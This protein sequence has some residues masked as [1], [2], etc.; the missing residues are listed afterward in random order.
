MRRHLIL[1]PLV[2]AACAPTPDSHKA[3]A[4]VASAAATPAVKPTAD[5][6]ADAAVLGAY[7]WRLQQ[8]ADGAGQRIDALF[9]RAD[10]PLQLD[11]ADGR[12]SVRNSC[13][14]M[15]GSYRVEN[16]QLVVGP[17]M[18]TMMACADL[19]LNQLDGAIS[20]RL[21]ARPAIAIGRQG[22]APQ[23]TLRTASGDQL[24]FA[25]VP[26]PETRYGGPGTTEFLEVAAQ[27][28]PCHHPLMPDRQCLDVREV[29]YDAQ[30]LKS[31]TP[32]AWQPFNQA[33]EGY[34]H[35]PGVRN[36]LRVKRYAVKNPPAD[37]PASAYVLDMVVETAIEKP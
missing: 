20:S 33:I 37:A 26:T 1:L 24:V 16:G 17:M 13:N 31:G 27:T 19:A 3:P 10:K 8:A 4:A 14:G 28:V 25:G 34:T 6:G 21:A 36:V 7:H 9:A 5:A 12:L 11:F 18:H 15:G 29:H 22:D 35:Q 30:G 23:L 2:L 32:G